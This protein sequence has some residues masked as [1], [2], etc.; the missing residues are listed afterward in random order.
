LSI[1]RFIF[2]IF[3]F[4]KKKEKK[5]KERKKEKKKEE[6]RKRWQWE[7]PARVVWE[8]PATYPTPMEVA[9]EIKKHYESFS[10]LFVK[11]FPFMSD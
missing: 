11:C 5:R 8:F 6:R 1:C 7:I 9:Y 10:S 2:V 4:K 3:F